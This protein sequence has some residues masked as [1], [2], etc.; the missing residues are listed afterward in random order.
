M[1]TTYGIHECFGA[2]VSEGSPWTNLSE[3][4]SSKIP[5]NLW[6]KQDNVRSVCEHSEKCHLIHTEVVLL[7]S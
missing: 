1:E 4:P 3:V 7:L 6:A 2:K 5:R